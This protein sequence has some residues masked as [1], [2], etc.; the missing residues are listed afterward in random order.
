MSTALFSKTFIEKINTNM[1]PVPLPIAPG[2]IFATL[3]KMEV[4]A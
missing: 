2:M 3:R 4:W 1:K